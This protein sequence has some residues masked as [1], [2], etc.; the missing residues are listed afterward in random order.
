MVLIH[1]VL[2]SSHLSVLLLLENEI[3]GPDL[4]M[5]FAAIVTTL[6][7]PMQCYMNVFKPI[8]AQNRLMTDFISLKVNGQKLCGFSKNI[9]P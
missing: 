1:T 6:Q 8:I 2:I 4:K 3:S 7:I 9:P 5:N